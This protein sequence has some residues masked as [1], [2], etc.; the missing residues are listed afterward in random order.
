MIVLCGSPT[1]LLH[2]RPLG[3]RR[4]R[5]RMMGERAQI[6]LGLPGRDTSPGP[7]LNVRRGESLLLLRLLSLPLL[8]LLRARPTDHGGGRGGALGGGDGAGAG[9]DPPRGFSG[10]GNG[11]PG[12]ARR[13]HFLVDV[14]L[15]VVVVGISLPPAPRPGRP[16]PRRRRLGRRRPRIADGD[17]AVRSKEEARDDFEAPS[18]R[19]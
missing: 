14:T 1:N 13:L 12:R 8:A 10:A 17:L 2:P 6:A 9:D 15:L 5:N 3:V 18:Y 19:T 7:A 4:L 16:H 11:R